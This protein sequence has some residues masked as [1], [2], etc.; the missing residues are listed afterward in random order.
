MIETEMVTINSRP[1]SIKS[2]TKA[3]GGVTVAIGAYIPVSD[4]FGV[5]GSFGNKTDSISYSNGYVGFTRTPID[6]LAYMHLDQHHSL[7]LGGTY[8]TNGKFTLEST[9]NPNLSFTADFDNATGAIAEYNYALLKSDEGGVKF[10]LR[11][12][13]IQYDLSDGSQSFDGSSFGVIIYAY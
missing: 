2:Q 7:A 13:H 4:M 9:D 1:V 5:Q 6:L 10:G 3:G 11:Y 12:T 8:H